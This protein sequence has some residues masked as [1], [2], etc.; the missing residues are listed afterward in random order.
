MISF[1]LAFG[2]S[3]IGSIPPGAINL[4]VIQYSIE[5]KINAAIRFSIASALVEFPYALIALLF[6]EFLLST[7]VILNNIKLISTSL[8]LVLAIINTYSYLFPSK[9]VNINKSMG[10]RKGL[11]ISI[12]N[13]LAIPFWIG[14]SA[15]LL[16]LKWIMLDSIEKKIVFAA[17]VSLGTLSL[18]FTL[19]V[20]AVKFKIK[21]ENQ[22]LSKLIPAIVFWLLGFY[23]IYQMI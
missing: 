7:D 4:S 18:L 2:F 3:F 22:G 8:I 1:L 10:F 9:K 17:G 15:F 5:D 19:I 23:G 16:N 12:F 14:V 13:P 6:S 11:L 20:I 21:V